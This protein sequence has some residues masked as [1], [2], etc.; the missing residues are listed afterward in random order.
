MTARGNKIEA[1]WTKLRQTGWYRQ[2]NINFNYH[3]IF[4][5]IYVMLLMS[6][7]KCKL[8]EKGFM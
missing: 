4:S 7:C 3:L 1:M 5:L 8:K 2:G 6:G